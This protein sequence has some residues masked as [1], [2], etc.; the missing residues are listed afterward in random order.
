MARFLRR[1]TAVSRDG[2]ETETLYKKKK[3]KKKKTSLWLRPMERRQRRTAKALKT[4]GD[5][6]L[7]RHNRSKRKRRN[8]WLRDGGLNTMRASRKAARKLLNI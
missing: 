7:S 6:L 2:D 3:K 1:V 5:T 8:G 4:F